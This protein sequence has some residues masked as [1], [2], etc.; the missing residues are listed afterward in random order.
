MDHAGQSL[1]TARALT[2]AA[3]VVAAS[4]SAMELM[5]GLALLAWLGRLII[6][7]RR[8]GMPDLELLLLLG[9]LAGWSILSALRS[10]DSSRAMV[11]VAAGL[12]WLAAP[13]ATAV[14]H[15]DGRRLVRAVLL[16]QAGLL[17]IWS[18][19]EFLLVWDGDPLRRVH[20][21]FSHHMTL[22]GFLLVAVLQGLPRPTL[23]PL[24]GTRWGRICGSVSA[25]LGVAGLMATLTRSVMLALACGLA[26]LLLS[27]PG[28]TRKGWRAALAVLIIVAVA[29][30][31][32]L[33][34]LMHQGEGLSDAGTASIDDRLHLWQAG[35][36]MIREH[37]W[38]GVGAH[39]TRQTVG[40]Y[41]DPEYRRAGMP[42]HLHGAWLTLAAER[43][44]PA[45]LILMA[46]YVRSGLRARKLL[47][48]SG[49]ADLVRGALAA[50]AGVLIMGLFEDNFD[51][52]EVLFVHMITLAAI[53]QLPAR[54]DGQRIPS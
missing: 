2:L 40:D 4:V 34:W 8:Q 13:L 37:P 19:A 18:V 54:A 46:L 28:S 3:V 23:W 50:L 45:L 24:L 9:V 47:A 52:S 20:G 49:E 17:G 25:L 11:S 38:F 53:W 41:L 6:G 7:S 30:G 16:L 22:A 44:L 26:V 1:R 31:V 42:A 15:G 10:A 33:P 12:L 36:N 43:G 35:W 21:P 14:L 27:A 29:A 51:D 32:S 5:L 48:R 39:L